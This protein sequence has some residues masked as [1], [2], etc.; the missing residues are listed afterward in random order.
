MVKKEND[1][2]D[3]GRKGG[4]LESD[5]CTELEL[6]VAATSNNEGAPTH[7][8]RFLLG[9]ETSVPWSVKVDRA[10][11]AE[12]PSAGPEVAAEEVTSPDEKGVRSAFFTATPM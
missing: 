9:S 5:R 8:L 12:R 7:R 6:V 4:L 1:S 2:K 3:G 11:G 10:T